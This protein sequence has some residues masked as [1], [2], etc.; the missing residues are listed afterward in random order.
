MIHQLANKF[1]VKSKSI[2]K[3]EQRRPELYRTKR[4]TPFSERSFAQAVSR[5][6]RQY[7]PRPDKR[8]YGRFSTAKPS[9]YAETSYKDGDVVGAAAPELSTDN[10]GR[11][12]LEKMGWSRGTALGTEDNQGILQPVTQTMKRSKAGLG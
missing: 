8:G 12:M 11:T 2:G 10:R 9:S 4:T 5:I 6:E 1:N 7:F 3:G